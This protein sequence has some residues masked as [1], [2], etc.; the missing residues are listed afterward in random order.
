MANLEQ[1]R[2]PYSL[3]FTEVFFRNTKVTSIINNETFD[4]MIS[5]IENSF[6]YDLYKIPIDLQHRPDLISSNF[7]GSPQ[8]W[9]L[10]MLVNNITDPFEGFNVNDIILIPKIA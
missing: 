5:D 6:N 4:R 8:N 1:N 3:G 10:L 7:Y 2:G 9:W